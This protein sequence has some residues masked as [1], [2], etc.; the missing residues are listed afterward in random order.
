MSVAHVGRRFA[1]QTAL[2]ATAALDMP[3]AAAEVAMHVE[4]APTAIAAAGYRA[5][6]A[7]DGCLT[8]LAIDGREFLAPGVAVSRGAYFFRAETLSLPGIDRPDK[9]TIVAVGSQARVE[10]RF[11]D[12]SMTWIV[13][14]ESERTTAFFIVLARH[15]EAV[16][17]RDG[18]VLAPA[19]VENCS[20]AAFANGDAKLDLQ[21][22]DRLWGPWQG[23]HQVCE[24]SLASH[25][26][27][28]LTLA[29]SRLTA[30][31]R[32]AVAALMQP[33]PGPALELYSPREYQ[34]V[35]RSSLERGACLVSGRVV[36]EADAIEFRVTGNSR[37]GELPG[38]WRPA[39]LT[40]DTGG[41]AQRIA[42]PAGGWYS[43]ELRARQGDKIVAETKVERFGVGEVFVGA[44]QSNSTNCGQF[45]TKQTSGMVASFGGNRWQ[46]G[47]DPQLGVADR[48]TGGSFWP[49]LGDALYQRYQVP[50]GVATTGFGGTSVDQWQPEGDLFP[51]TMTRIRQLGP[52]GFRAL[53]WHQ[54]ESDVA[55]SADEYYG[56]IARV[57]RASRTE[58]GWQ[59]PW[60]VAQATYHNV[61]RPQSE[62][63]R[64]AQQRLWDEGLALRG[65]DTDAL[66][67][68]YRDLDG[69]G[70]HFNP[71]G[72]RRHGEM[73][74]ELV[75]PF[76]DRELGIPA[77]ATAPAGRSAWTARQWPEA[78]VLFHRD[79][80]WLGSDDAY[81]IDLGNGRIAW[82]FGDSFV[83]P[84]TPGLR[85]GTTMVRNSIG[86]QTGYDPTTADFKGYWRRGGLRPASLI[87]D[88]GEDFYW[89]GG[90]VVLGDKLLLF[91][92]RAANADEGLGFRSTGWGA[93]LCSG[94]DQPPDRWRIDKLAV[95]QNDFETLV[96]SGSV[97]AEGDCVYAFSHCPRG[98]Q[99]LRWD[100]SD[101]AVGDLSRARWYDR[102]RDVWIE[103]AELQK[104]PE[105]I[106][107]PGQT[108]F[109]VHRLPKQGLYLQ[110]QFLGFPRTVIGYR[111]APK[112]TGPW[113]TLA[114]L[115]APQELAA[116]DSEVM[117]YAGKLHPE[118][119]ADGI[120]L[121]YASNSFGLSRVVTDQS[122]YFPRF[123]LVTPAPAD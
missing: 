72:L 87:A 78:D 57:I 109:T 95:P 49:A 89:P 94:I 98:I 31:E 22:I 64:A 99:L 42:L 3:F 110:V 82:F 25:E 63:V 45:P 88:D 14:N 84:T 96:G 37:F 122:L 58:A 86:I 56:K 10:Y 68:E 105:P 97:V 102:R 41:F 16:L 103:Q 6:V 17:L 47:D 2:I 60:F 121:T 30:E 79:P 108:E 69:K 66:Q 27:R 73:W 11:A 90:G 92:M 34:V 120:A 91:L 32:R 23:P 52:G 112:L 67:E 54:G 5:V 107:A 12:D 59:I 61:E 24:A 53:L 20:A 19:V 44:G 28:T 40:P 50:I 70:I 111:T 113:S 101:A 71:R 15:V 33:M 119:Q 106:F 13:T 115:F 55:L 123:A 116:D 18:R 83:E 26:T 75:T 46:L 77:P 36:V 118:Q 35:Q 93:V 38:G 1:I 29:A 85:R 76:V 9:A 100:R 117:L 65:P 104:L 80:Q 21:G 43:F 8:N 51:W 74:A 81:S 48:S 62:G 4:P 114:T 7:G 39:R